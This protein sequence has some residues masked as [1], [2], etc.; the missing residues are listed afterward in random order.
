MFIKSIFQVGIV[1]A[2]NDCSFSTLENGISAN[3]RERKKGDIR[4]QF[5]WSTAK[6]LPNLRD[7]R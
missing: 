3:K 2:E 1:T 6:M 4:R 7:N 5:L